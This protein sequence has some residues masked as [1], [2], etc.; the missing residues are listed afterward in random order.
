MRSGCSKFQSSGASPLMRPMANRLV[1]VAPSARRKGR[2]ASNCCNLSDM[3]RTLAPRVRSDKGGGRKNSFLDQV[4]EN[5]ARGLLGR[6]V[7]EKLAAAGLHL[8]G[9]AQ[10]LGGAAARGK[11]E[12]LGFRPGG[13]LAEAG[14]GP[15]RRRDI[16]DHELARPH[17]AEGALTAGRGGP[18]DGEQG[19]QAG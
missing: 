10:A 15:C 7:E 18:V 3:G 19:R 1:P 2:S 11:P 6:R 4:V 14:V 5:G 9:G 17:P 12:A 8:R 16:E 13:Y